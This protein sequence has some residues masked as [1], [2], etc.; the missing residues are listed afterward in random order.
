MNYA[1]EF[2]VKAE[3]GLNNS[4][5]HDKVYGYGVSIVV[6]EGESQGQAK[7]LHF[8]FFGK[9]A[10]VEQAINN[11]RAGSQLP[12][13]IRLSRALRS[14]Q[15]TAMQEIR[16]WHEKVLTASSA[17]Y[18]K[19][20]EKVSRGYGRYDSMAVR[21]LAS[22]YSEVSQGYNF[23]YANSITNAAGINVYDYLGEINGDVS[24]PVETPFPAMT[25]EP[26]WMDETIS[27]SPTPSP[28]LSVADYDGETDLSTVLARI[29]RNAV[30]AI[31]P[32][33]PAPR[34]KRR[35]ISLD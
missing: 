18:L 34:K 13:G 10:S 22:H 35:A 32:P 19:M 25:P 21:L 30:Q 12:R 31:Q 14:F 15:K 8:N 27:P 16:G 5:G 26:S 28:S 23:K 4:P 7:I 2:L 33:A 24:Q 29:N 17:P 20:L 6:A 9:R 3:M 1:F 11:C